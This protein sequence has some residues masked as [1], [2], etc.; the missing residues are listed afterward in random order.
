MNSRK[1][2]L[3]SPY[4]LPGQHP[5]MLG[6]EEMAAWLN[7][8]T[9]L[10]HPAVLYLAG[11]PPIVDPPYDYEQ[12][13][14]EQVF[15]VP[16]SP[17]LY[18]PDDWEQR[19]QTVG[20][21][22]FRAGADRATT[23]ANLKKN[24]E[25]RSDDPVLHKLLAI[26]QADVAP[27]FGIGLGYLLLATLC[28]GMEHENLLQA[29]PFWQDV[30][31]AVALLAGLPVSFAPALEAPAPA[32]G[33]QAQGFDG[34]PSIDEPVSTPPAAPAPLVTDPEA[35]LDAL[36][37]AGNRLLSAREVLY[38]VPI[39]LIELVL[40]D[41]DKPA[42][43]WPL[44]IERGFFT[45]LVAA[46]SVLEKLGRDQPERLAELRERVQGEQVEVCGGCYLE[47]EDALMPIE[48]QLWNL[49]KGLEVSKQLLGSDLRVFARKRFGSHPQTPLLLQSV[50]LSKAIFLPFD[51]SALPEYQT[52]VISWPAPD[53]KT[54][55]AFV[56]KPRPAD[57]P[58][59]FFNLAHFLF[60]TI[61]EDHT[62]TVAIVHNGKPAAPWLDD[63]QQLCRFGPIMG[64]WTT[65]T[66]Y[67]A[68]VHAGE[69]TA[70]LSPD[71]FHGDYLSE[72]VKQ[73]GGMP[74]SGFAR[75]LKHRRRI[76]TCWTLAAIQRGL[77]GVN[78]P[79]N[80]DAKI[81]ELEDAIEAGAPG[82]LSPELTAKLTD[83]EKE[84]AGTLSDRLL[85]RATAN[86]PGY[87]VLNP[88]SFTRRVTL[89]VDG[90]PLPLA[91]GGPVKACQ[92]EGGKLRAVVEVPALGFAWIPKSGPPGTVQAPG[93]I[94]LADNSCVRNEFFE[95]EI[96]P[97]TGGLRGIRD[98]RTL[99]NRVAQ[100]L[101]FHPG[102]LMKASAIRV[103][104]TG[105]A[106]GEIV[107]EGT[108][109][110]EQQQVLARFRQRF[111]AW[112]GRPML[113]LRIELFPEQP[114]AGYPWHAFY[115]ARFAWRD[116]R[117]VMLRSVN[118]T[119]YLTNHLR[120]QTP[121]YLD[122]RLA[123]QS[124]T[125]FPDGLPFHQRA[126]GRMVDVI[127]IPEGET[128]TVFELGVG[129]DRELPAQTALGLATPVTVVPTTKGPPHIGATGWLFHLDAPNV[130]LMSLRP[131]CLEPARDGADPAARRDALTARLLECG[132]FNSHAEFRCVRDPKRAVLLN[133]LG[134]FL[135]DG[136]VSG[137]AAMF[138]MQPGELGH[139]QVQFT[140]PPPDQA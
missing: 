10:W 7:A 112:L 123:R 13:K 25:A 62:A 14:E 94:K 36:Q 9:A 95:A 127:L 26:D 21:V 78:D 4:R 110:G 43:H 83:L 44:S 65:L 64:Q 48:S 57:N 75:H 134:G 67:L 136:Q 97:T 19:V 128:A 90:G 121:D 61:R 116:E 37:L 96:D 68:E 82:V 8:Y 117:A 69:Y 80:A 111:R 125:I 27:F 59:T 47:R 81:T 42:D 122:L 126:E 40:L 124:T 135:L 66:R 54:I 120:P 109:V 77:A 63:W 46:G 138:E 18:M 6:E 24:L 70:A 88:C 86:E 15:A 51:E 31:N 129:I 137:D 32:T 2:I 11:G 140:A 130:L 132:A 17:P 119:G 20:A 84:I 115:G 12:P 5:L 29:E 72:R 118:G 41:A 34:P 39:H 55:D 133:S 114:P 101:V 79:Q 33:G 102:S 35:Y 76:D 71:E 1:L 104:S 53:G 73:A 85:S 45:N 103:T 105:P 16:E 52:T 92:L 106:L 56:R 28:E 50:G 99:M 131:G 93:K 98:Y 30:K 91:I 100:R 49:L 108:L 38:P 113:E 87:L 139:L 3:L 22:S 60:K 74:V 107:T 58:E 89:E 23:L